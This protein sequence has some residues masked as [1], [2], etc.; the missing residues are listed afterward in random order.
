MPNDVVCVYL[1]VCM[2]VYMCMKV[3]VCVCVCMRTCV[4][5]VCEGVCILH[6]YCPRVRTF[7]QCICMEVYLHHFVLPAC[8]LCAILNTGT[9]CVSIHVFVC[10]SLHIYDMGVLRVSM[11]EAEH[12]TQLRCTVASVW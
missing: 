7:H 5:G 9:S 10:A 8:L 11:K 3:C 4:W 12:Y 2:Y 1:C 6:V